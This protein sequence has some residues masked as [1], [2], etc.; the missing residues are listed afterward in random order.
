M[1]SKLKANRHKLGFSNS[2]S[3]TRTGKSEDLIPS[4]MW[5][6]QLKVKGLLKAN[7]DKLNFSKMSFFRTGDSE[8]LVQLEEGRGAV[9]AQG[10]QTQTQLFKQLQL[11]AH[12]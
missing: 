4:G 9:E 5:C 12:R 6:A 2:F 11:H 7:R 10:K 3:F 1:R 8:E